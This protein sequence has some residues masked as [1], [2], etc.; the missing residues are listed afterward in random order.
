MS[1]N[2]YL[3]QNDTSMVRERNIKTRGKK[4]KM[5]DINPTL[6]VITLSVTRMNT[7]R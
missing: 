7:K 6:T 3:T 1:E 4:P 2:I 5:V